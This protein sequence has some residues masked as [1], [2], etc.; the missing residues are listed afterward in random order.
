MMTRFGEYPRYW[1]GVVGDNVRRLRRRRG[2]TQQELGTRLAWHGWPTGNGSNSVISRLERAT[3]DASG[4]ATVKVTIDRLMLLA[5]V[6]DVPYRE[7]LR[8]ND[9]DDDDD[10]E[11]R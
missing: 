1:D 6:L 9:D 8:E 3:S 5:R 11:K 2:W 7:L 4:N 10:E